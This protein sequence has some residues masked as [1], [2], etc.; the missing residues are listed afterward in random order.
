E[1]FATALIFASRRWGDGTGIYDYGSEARALL[2]VMLH[3]GESPEAQAAGATSIFDPTAH[4]VVFVPSN[5]TA[6][7]TDPSYVMPAFYEVWACFDAKNRAAWKQIA[8][9]SR[10]YLPKATDVTTGL[11]P[12]LAGFDG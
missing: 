12:E 1:Y 5:F 2:D 10:A 9:A 11:A 6:T 4:L 8:A 3:R 7:F